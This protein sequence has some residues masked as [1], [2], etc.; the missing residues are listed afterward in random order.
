[1]RYTVYIFFIGAIFSCSSTNFFNKKDK[2]SDYI[3][4]NSKYKLEWEDFK[5][6]EDIQSEYDA[7]SYTLID[8]RQKGLLEDKILY[9]I[10][11]YFVS[12]LSWVKKDQKN[13]DLL[14]HEQLHF[15]I[16][17]LYA[18]KFRKICLEHTSHNL[19]STFKYFNK[20]YDKM[21]IEE[22]DF[23]HQYDT[24]TNYS[25]NKEKQKEWVKKVK[26]LLKEYEAY[27]DTY[28]EIKRVKK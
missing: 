17:E 7:I 11:T 9:E 1:M 23:Q 28:I 3:L 15:D 19:N 12:S 8:Q 18:R 24:E 21:L 2:Q 25:K 14:F 22:L 13:N 26:A 16:S 5:G 4:W 6:K 20:E 27:A 10:A